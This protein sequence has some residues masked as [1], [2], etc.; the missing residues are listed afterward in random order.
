MQSRVYFPS[1][2]KCS[3]TNPFFWLMLFS[4]SS[5]AF[6]ETT[7]NSWNF[8]VVTQ[9]GGGPAHATHV[10]GNRAYLGIGRHM[11]VLDVSD[12]T[13][14]Q[15][16]G[17]ILLPGAMADVAVSSETAMFLAH[18][19]LWFMDVGDPATTVSRVQFMGGGGPGV[20]VSYSG[21]HFF[22]G[23]GDRLDVYGMDPGSSPVLR[24]S[25]PFM[26]GMTDFHVSGD[27]VYSAHSDHAT[28]PVVRHLTILNVADPT[29]PMLIASMP[30]PD[31]GSMVHAAGH[32]VFLAGN[33]PDG[34]GGFSVFDANDPT[35]PAFLGMWQ[36]ANVL[37]RDMFVDDGM[38]YMT[39]A[40][41]GG[42]KIVNVADP[43]SPTWA[44]DYHHPHSQ[45]LP[46]QIEVHDR[47]AY[48]TWHGGL[49][50]V[51]VTN[52]S[53]PVL[54]GTYEE[55]AACWDVHTSGGLTHMLGHGMH[56]DHS[57]YGMFD[58]HDPHHP[59]L[60]G[61]TAG[62]FGNS[63]QNRLGIMSG[64]AY[65]ANP[66]QLYVLDIHD[67][68]SPTA[69]T[70]YTW[71]CQTRYGTQVAH[72][73]LFYY[74]GGGQLDVLD[75]SDPSSPT[76]G[77]HGGGGMMGG[78]PE[79]GGGMGSSGPFSI[80]G[81]RAYTVGGGMMN[82]GLNTYD[83]SSPHSPVLL[84]NFPMDTSNISDIHAMDHMVYIT[85]GGL[86][87]HDMT[88]P[89]QPMF[90]GYYPSWER[91]VIVADGVAYL[92]TSAVSADAGVRTLEAVDVSEPSTPRLRAR[93]SMS[94][95]GAGD[96]ASASWL[97]SVSV[98]GAFVYVSA[99]AE[100]LW[101]LRLQDERQTPVSGSRWP[102]FP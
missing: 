87:I 90:R 20:G 77:H 46:A 1:Y 5:P 67:P 19:G 50:I 43:T 98:D 44:G 8:D 17:R 16:M 91:N 94:V 48:Y 70:T 95:E 75:M 9:I 28:S 35:T 36:N 21:G 12:P 30:M 41:S 23:I 72:D 65:V 26:A 80:S 10:D 33:L 71:T 51:D 40:Q 3:K 49:Q 68:S 27:R 29:S 39:D 101:V 88:D 83:I 76:Q 22:A 62:F 52:P 18:G 100:G 53:S 24:G 45:G 82:S 84:G 42:F 74:G 7:M 15:V 34:T 86:H 99:G 54:R 73:H 13:S 14:P 57:T 59:V 66:Q 78:S 11:T 63:Y 79:M 97:S 89:G 61:A 69:L 38:V 31:F 37:V 81:D 102:L 64:H 96:P 60:Q 85:S 56:G 25:Y 58:S 47:M 4:L 93:F 92:Y 55:P 32:R 6:A 2:R